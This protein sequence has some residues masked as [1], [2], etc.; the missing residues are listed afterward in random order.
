MIQ[1]S[2]NVD[3]LQRGTILVPSSAELVD[4]VMGC[5]LRQPGA[6]RHD[7]I[8]LVQHPVELQ[9]DFRG[10]VLGVF[11]LTKKLSTGL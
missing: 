2:A 10:G 9:K 8:F 1:E 11:G 5:Y 7:L 6:E 4:T 3:V